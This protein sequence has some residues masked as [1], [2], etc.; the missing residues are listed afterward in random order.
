MPFSQ[1]SRSAFLLFIHFCAIGSV[2]IRKRSAWIAS[3]T[4]FGDVGRLLDRTQRVARDA[5]FG[6]AEH[7]RAHA[8]RGQQRHANALV[9]VR[10]RQPLG[11]ADHRVFRHRIRQVAVRGEDAG[12]RRGVQQIAF[13]AFEHAG[14][15]RANGV[16][17]A[18]QIDL[19][20]IVPHVDRRGQRS[21][22]R[23]RRPRC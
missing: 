21:D 22:R 19:P 13:A 3:T 1:R 6:V 7:R 18:H 2:R 17:V 23:L 5:A 12:H 9:V 14:Q 15:H 4:M 20:L 10:D 8:E 16:D 11:E